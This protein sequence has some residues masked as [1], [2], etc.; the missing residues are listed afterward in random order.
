MQETALTT[1]C[2]SMWF[3]KIGSSLMS[4]L[5]GSQI[6]FTDDDAARVATIARVVA[7]AIHAS[8]GDARSARDTARR[9]VIIMRRAEGLCRLMI[10]R[11]KQGTMFQGRP[12]SCVR[13]LIFRFRHDRR[14]STRQNAAAGDPAC[15]GAAPH[16]KYRSKVQPGEG[17]GGAAR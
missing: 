10:L 17:M 11:P 12:S 15:G 8:A 14:A 1:H 4:S 16:P 9:T 7:P 5:V 6:M 13:E 3:F 2:C